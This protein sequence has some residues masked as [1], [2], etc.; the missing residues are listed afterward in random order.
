METTPMSTRNTDKQ[1][2]VYPYHRILF[3]Q[4]RKHIL[5]HAVLWTHRGSIYCLLTPGTENKSSGLGVTQ[6]CGL[7]QATST[8]LLCDLGEVAA[9]L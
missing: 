1:A 4:K 2:T 9:S 3:S 6:T 5:I 7:P 8:F